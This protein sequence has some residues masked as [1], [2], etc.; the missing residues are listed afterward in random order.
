[1]LG[2]KVRVTL[3]PGSEVAPRWPFP[4]LVPDDAVG[5]GVL[6]DPADSRERLAALV[7]SPRN[8][9]FAKVLVN[10]LWQR[11]LGW[12]LVDPVDDWDAA[13]GEASHPELLDRLAR[14]LAGHG[15][16]QR[17]VARL[18]LNSRTYQR[19]VRPDGAGERVAEG[20][21]V[22]GAVRRRLTAEQL[23]DSLFVAAGKPLGSEE[24]NLDVD[25][26]RPV[27]DFNNLGRPT[28]AWEFTSLSNER[29]RPALAM[30]RAQALVDCLVTFGWRDSRQGPQALRDHAVNVLQPA[31][32]ANGGVIHG[33]VARLSEDSAFTALALEE[34]PVAALVEA[35]F[36]RVLSRLPDEGERAVFVAQLAEGYADRR[37]PPSG[38]QARAARPA[39]RAV[40]WSNHLNPEATRL[41]Q[42]AER[43][44]RAGDPPTDR[45]RAAWRERMEDAVWSLVNSPEF[46][47]IP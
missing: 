23:L 22:G 33:R 28:R 43:A 34:R 46:L 27:K 19:A 26:R 14:E 3:P 41:K 32:L 10:R 24:M 12:A 5:E 16:D 30:P 35:L 36:L 42:E 8:E 1:V 38:T 20:R 6:R 39:E 44:A 2:K 40:S 4:E 9:R 37:L 21:L 45:L 11:Y 47:F 13:G 15:Y 31:A 18:I 25:G 17:H 7:T 29:D